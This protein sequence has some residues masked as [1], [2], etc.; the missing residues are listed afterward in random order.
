MT[1]NLHETKKLAFLMFLAFAIS[2][3]ARLY[4]AY[5]A[6]GVESFSFAGQTMINTNDG[7]FYA[8]GARDLIKG[9]HEA[10]D[11]S[12]VGEPIAVATMLI[13]KILPFSFESII[14]Y[15]PAFFGSLIVVPIILIAR[16]FGQST[17]GFFAAIFAAT[18]YSYYNR[19]MIG[20]YDSDMF[21]LIMPP[22]VAAFIIGYFKEK[23]VLWQALLLFSLALSKILYPQSFSWMAATIAFAL[24]Y[25]VVFDRK[26]RGIYLT[27]ALSLVAISDL[28]TA[29]K[30]LAIASAIYFQPKITE[31]NKFLIG[32]GAICVAIFA[33][34]GGLNPIISALKAYIFKDSFTVTTT[35]KYYDVV[36]TVREAGKMDPNLFASR[37]SGSMPIFIIAILG[38]AFFIKKEKLF[39]LT[40]PIFGL[41]L[42]AY[43]G[44][45]R[46]TVYAVPFAALGLFFLIF[47]GV[48]KLNEQARVAVATI[49]FLIAS[50][51]NFYHIYDYKIPTVFS[52]TL[53][54]QLTE[55]GK[56]AGREDYVFAWWDYGYPIRYYSDVKNHSDGGKHDGSTNFIES[57]ILGSTSQ[58]AAANMMRDSVEGY[59]E[60]IK[61]GEEQNR[62]TLEYL[63]SK[64]GIEPKNYQDYLA[65][66]KSEEFKAATKT[67]D[68]Y[69]FLP[70]EMFEIFPTVKLFSDVDLISGQQASEPYFG[71]F[72]DFVE[73]EDSIDLGGVVFD[74]KT[75]T[76]KMGQNKL[77]L[78]TIS[79]SYYDKNGSLVTKTQKLSETAE[80]HLI[81]LPS[82]HAYILADDAS[83]NSLFVQLF[84]FE[85]YDKNLFEK[86]SSTP[87]AKIFR[88]KI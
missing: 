85:N 27:I 86:V 54:K 11:R 76:I 46:F 64:K 31:N 28:H 79:S 80:F 70:F 33:Y 29:L 4:W 63:L 58:R 41:G 61:K 23:R 55:L 44:G 81:A 21:A 69:L 40:L 84:V 3:V 68:V 71:L 20:Y 13:C 9:S 19:T 42:F 72:L 87:E 32:A 73:N 67:R 35:L 10:G 14:L 88:L 1:K 65:S 39:A 60:L 43:M 52:N 8:E 34:M 51:P 82:H 57:F 12:G 38:Y 47:W 17:M 77:S 7:Y 30:V 18:T 48:R 22:F 36:Q 56:I 26:D 75:N 78:K 62:S 24:V 6:S 49:A 16:I 2:I 59:E 25:T 5:W 37:I 50:V 45:L 53:A 15:M 74:K 83:F 66:L